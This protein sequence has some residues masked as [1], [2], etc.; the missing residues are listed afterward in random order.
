MPDYT[1]T[2][3][4]Q[5]SG[6]EHVTFQIKRDGVN[7]RRIT[8][9]KSEIIDGNLTLEA[10]LPVLLKKAIKNAGA[11]TPAQIKNAIEALVVTL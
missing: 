7:L 10:A 3:G 6:G 2:F 4:S 11:T 5:C 1:L 9:N 8:L